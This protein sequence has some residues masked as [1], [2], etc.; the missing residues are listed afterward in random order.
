V[1][2]HVDHGWRTEEERA[3]EAKTVAAWCHRLGVSLRSFPAPIPIPIDEDAARK[4]RYSCFQTF[5]AEH[6]ASPI[7]LAH[8]ADDQAETVL[9]RL[10][11]GRSWQGLAGMS[12][13]RGAFRRPFLGL[14][15]SL[16]AEVAASEDIVYHDDST[17]AD[18]GFSRNF[19]RLQVF[20]LVSQR[21]P[22]AVEA[23]ND[24]AR[25]WSQLAP[26]GTLD[27]G[28][29]ID[30][31]GGTIAIASWNQWR[32]LERQAQLLAVANSLGSWKWRRRFLEELVADGRTESGQGGGWAWHHRGSEVRWEK[33]VQ[34]A[35]REY[36]I[37]AEPGREYDL[38]SYRVS[39]S[40]RSGDGRFFVPGPDP[41]KPLVWRSAV[42]GMRFA[43]VDDEDWGKPRRRRR[44]GS[45]KPER[46]ALL[47]Q[48]GLIRAALDPQTNRV[49]WVETGVE[50]LHKTGIFVKLIERSVYERR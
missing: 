37:L 21:F 44:L 40:S 2:L 30:A 18:P 47:V 14:R 23:L 31:L 15:A 24:F 16:L 32:P 39:W 20:P 3:E 6:P 33:V 48:E 38:G 49:L 9:M 29:A 1:A 26:S 41:S 25:A 43:S 27:P 5:L 17:N 35:S 28:W 12:D 8:H 22:R 34:P 13:E 4:H 50:K 42:G 19:L 7:F 10:L 11:K 46:C 36:F 45:M